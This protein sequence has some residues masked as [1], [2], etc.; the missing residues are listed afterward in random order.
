MRKIISLVSILSLIVLL[1]GCNGIKPNTDD[2]NPTPPETN[3]PTFEQPNDSNDNEIIHVGNHEPDETTPSP[4]INQSVT[5]TFENIRTMKEEI[6]EKRNNETQ[7]SIYTL[8]SINTSDLKEL[9]GLNTD[10][11]ESWVEWSGDDTYVIYYTTT[12]SVIAFIPFSS[13]DLLQEEMENW[14]LSD[15]TYENLLANNLVTDVEF[16]NLP[17]TTGTS[18]QCTYNTNRVTGLILRYHTYTNPESNITYILSETL[19]PDNQLQSKSLFVFAGDKSFMCN[20]ND[21][22]LTITTACDL[23]CSNIQ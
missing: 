11:I 21:V 15:G 3:E 17:T 5:Q 12:D 13:E 10:Y 22:S 7:S 19:S 2:T 20:G 23:Y 18:Y 8:S 16:A 9:K 6:D 14:L 1:V 4:P